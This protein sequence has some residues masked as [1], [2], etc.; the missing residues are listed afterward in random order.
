VHTKATNHDHRW[1]VATQPPVG[2]NDFTKG[3]GI[4]RC[5]WS[6]HLI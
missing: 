3:P 2:G 5:Q 4:C 1:P 6:L